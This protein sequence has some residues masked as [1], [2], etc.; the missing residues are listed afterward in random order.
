MHTCT[1][2]YT[3]VHVCTIVRMYTEQTTPTLGVV[4]A[5]P[6]NQQLVPVTSSYWINYLLREKEELLLKHR[7]QPCFIIR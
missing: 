5:S 7:L 6:S 4:A 2:M 1:Y 3:Y